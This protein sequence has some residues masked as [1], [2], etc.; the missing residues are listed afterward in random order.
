LSGKNKVLKNLSEENSS[1]KKVLLRKMTL[2]KSFS[3]KKGYLEQIC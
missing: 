3:G 2:Q 1:F